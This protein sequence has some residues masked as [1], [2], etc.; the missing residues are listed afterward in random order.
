MGKSRK[1]SPAEVESNNETRHAVLSILNHGSNALVKLAIALAFVVALI[2]GAKAAYRFG[3]S[4]FTGGPMEEAPG[5]DVEVT[6][7]PG[8]SDKN[9]GVLLHREGLVRN[10]NVFL[11][12]AKIYGYKIQPG[13]YTLN[14]SQTIAE[15]LI[16]LSVVPETAE[17]T[18]A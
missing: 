2:Y 4:V 1:L 16:R 9:V 13:T 12:Q 15:M 14:T 3:Y 11:V 10:S 18:A 7:L 5:R 17:N 8:T 6:I